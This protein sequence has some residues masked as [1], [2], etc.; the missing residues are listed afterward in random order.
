[1]KTAVSDNPSTLSSRSIQLDAALWS[2]ANPWLVE[3]QADDRPP[4]DGSVTNSGGTPAS[5]RAL[6]RRCHQLNFK[7]WS[8][9]RHD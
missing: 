7:K 2:L 9:A 5:R 6:A 8:Q 3:G 4:M 1:M